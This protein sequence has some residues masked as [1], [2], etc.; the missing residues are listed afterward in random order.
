[1]EKNARKGKQPNLF[2][3]FPHLSLKAPPFIRQPDRPRTQNRFAHPT[4]PG[5][6]S[7]RSLPAHTSPPGARAPHPAADRSGGAAG[8]DVGWRAGT[9]EGSVRSGRRRALSFPF[10]SQ[11]PSP[12]AGH[13]PRCQRPAERRCPCLFLWPVY[14]GEDDSRAPRGR[15]RRTLPQLLRPVVREEDVGLALLFRFIQVVVHPSW[16]HA[17]GMVRFFSSWPTRHGRKPAETVWH[18]AVGNRWRYRQVLTPAVNS[19]H[20]AHP[21]RFN[22][23]P[24]DAVLN[25]AFTHRS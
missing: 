16:T 23:I 24:V 20:V 18:R 2:P 8:G 10:C 4:T 9:A 25:K 19:S 15:V 13:A 6:D 14:G 7:A 21:H 22:L 17:A 1:V 3:H 5:G 11:S 12:L